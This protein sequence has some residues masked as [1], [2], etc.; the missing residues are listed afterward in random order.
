VSAISNKELL[1]NEQIR[2]KEVRVIDSDGSQLGIISIKEAQN[3]AIS[4][5]LD[6]VNISP[7]ANPP[8]CKIMDYGKYRFENSKK[9]KE[10]KKNQKIVDVKELRLSVNIDVNDFNTKVAHAQKF[11][12]F[13]NRVKV[14]IRFRGREMMHTQLGDSLMSKFAECCTEFGVVEKIPKIEGRSMIMYIASK[15]VK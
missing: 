15:Q 5:N 11:L 13:G 9:E 3:I 4:K 12:K 1:I 8:V 10:A 6:L 7:S 14:T 2:D